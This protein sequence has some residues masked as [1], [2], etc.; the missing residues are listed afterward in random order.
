[1]TVPPSALARCVAGISAQQDRMLMHVAELI[2]MGFSGA[3]WQLD[4]HMRGGAHTLLALLRASLKF[5]SFS[6]NCLVNID[7][8]DGEAS[9][10]A[11]HSKSRPVE[12]RSGVRQ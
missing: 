3:C 6:T 8:N 10:F 2:L 12:T 1:M 11:A 9:L 5:S 4:L 7:T